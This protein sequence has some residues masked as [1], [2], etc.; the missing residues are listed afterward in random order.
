MR[1]SRLLLPASALLLC[2]RLCTAEPAAVEQDAALKAATAWLAILDA[3]KY[4]QAGSGFAEEWYATLVNLPT[5]ARKAESTTAILFQSRY[6]LGINSAYTVV[7]KLQPDGVK[8]L[9][10]CQCGLP[11]GDF[12]EFTYAV[13]FAWNDRVLRSIRFTR[14]AHEV[15]YMLRENDRTWKPAALFTQAVGG[16]G[17]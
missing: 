9:R 6:S 3:G 10:S 7:R 8:H 15:L 12:F 5:Q 14:Q 16:F 17:H 2:A 11:D 1:A 4:G 13:K